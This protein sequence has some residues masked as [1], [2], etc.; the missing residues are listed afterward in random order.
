MA[1]LVKE[2]GVRPA[3]WSGTAGAAAAPAVRDGVVSRPGLFGLLD[4]AGR[5]TEVS[6]PAGSGKTLLLRSWIEENG[7]AQ[8]TAWV[9][10][11]SDER[12][13]QRFWLSVLGALRDTAAG[14]SLVRPLTAA[15][16]LDGGAVVERLLADLGGL[17]DRVLAGDRRRARAALGRGAAPAGAAAHARARGPAVHPG[18]PP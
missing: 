10:V 12:D 7:R 1:E 2:G 17:Q 13:P 3:G 9:P 14:S 8:R 6:A 5:V 15:P 16:D 11:Q 18:H 4:A